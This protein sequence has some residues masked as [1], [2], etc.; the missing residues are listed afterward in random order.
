MTG[1]NTPRSD[2]PR[3]EPDPGPGLEDPR[4]IHPSP[5]GVFPEPGETPLRED[6]SEFDST[7]QEDDRE[8]GDVDRGI[9]D[10]RNE[11]IGP[12]I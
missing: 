4:T 9:L 3:P 5:E 1:S 7:S 2:E 6:S 11:T 10:P 12:D 8:S